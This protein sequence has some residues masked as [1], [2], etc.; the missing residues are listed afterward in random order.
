MDL[1]PDSPADAPPSIPL[2]A[3][4][5]AMNGEHTIAVGPS[6]GE[7]H[8]TSRFVCDSGSSTGTLNGRPFPLPQPIP[9]TTVT[10]SYDQDGKVLEIAS[11][12]GDTAS[13]GTAATQMLRQA[14]AAAPT[15]TLSVGESFAAPTAITFP[16]A[17]VAGAPIGIAGTM[18]YTLTSVTY[19]GAD[20]IAHL[21]LSSKMTLSQPT[22]GVGVDMQMTGVGRMDVSIDRGVVLHTDTHTTI[23]GRMQA[24]GS[25]LPSTTRMHGTITMSADVTR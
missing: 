10:V 5:M 17:G 15:M 23:D 12:Q 24:P 6:D 25:T 9:G 20:R 14:V 13:I 18:R 3:M 4:V 19:D 21:A 16:L 11:D 8:Y 22:P 1:A 7:G 2:M